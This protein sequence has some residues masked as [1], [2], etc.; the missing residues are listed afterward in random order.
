MK[1]EQYAYRD[2]RTKK[3][4]ARRLWIVRVNAAARANG[5]RYSELIDWLTK[6]DIE[7]DRRVLADIALHQP[8]DFTTIVETARR[9]ANG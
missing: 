4:E 7:L 8:E 6:A 5:V 9:L 3:R 1:S 2:R